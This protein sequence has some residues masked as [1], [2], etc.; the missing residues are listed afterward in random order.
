M[1]PINFSKPR[2]AGA[3]GFLVY[4]VF[5]EIANN[6]RL[7][8]RLACMMSDEHL[9]N[10]DISSDRIVPHMQDTKNAQYIW[11]L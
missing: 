11:C 9:K 3:H 2:W 8:E 6:V 10:D 7:S 1:Q 4:N 5:G